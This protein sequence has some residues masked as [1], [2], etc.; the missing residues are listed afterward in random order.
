MGR[1]SH[2]EFGRDETFREEPT[3]E[4]VRDERYYFTRAEDYFKEGVF[5]GSL[6]YYSRALEFNAR[7]P[8]AWFGQVRSLIELNEPHEA[9]IWADKGLEQFRN[10]PE[11]L[12][13]KGVAWTRLG[14]L[15]KAMALSDSALA[16]KGASAYRW[17]ARGETLL[18]R[19]DP[20]EA[21]CFDKALAAAPGDWF[22]PLEIGRVYLYYRR[23]APALRH[24][25]LA[26][27]RRSSSAYLWENMGKCLERMGM[28]GRAHQAYR[29]ALDLDPHRQ[30]AQEGLNRLAAH[31]WLD[32]FIGFFRSLFHR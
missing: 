28:A 16:E 2:L 30:T 27:E 20:N 23:Y 7:L 25:E 18:A 12:A 21:Y 22:E 1:F 13:A 32:R 26:S 6:R 29:N 17:R 9:R 15:D 5:E 19:R 31:G 14:D 24:L 11:L 8:E 4:A 10:H 3:T